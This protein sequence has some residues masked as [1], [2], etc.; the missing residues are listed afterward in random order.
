MKITIHG[1]ARIL[2]LAAALIYL[3]G[4]KRK[5]DTHPPPPVIVEV[6]EV[7]GQDVPVYHDWIGTLEGLVNAQIR[8]Q[9]SGYLLTQNYREGDPVKKGDLLFQIDPRP[10]Q[11]ALDQAKG[12]LAQ[13]EAQSGK[14]ELDVKRFTPLAKVSA[15]SQQELD[16]AVQA[17]LAAKA[18]VT[19]AKAAVEQAKLNLEF[20]H[21][22]SPIDG[23]P[24]I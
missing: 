22:L 1:D 13:A 23:I 4:C 15:I 10:F 7:K 14:T 11:A 5:V 3:A 20:T 12:Q 21:L 2:I 17:N 8:A 18:A 9:V 24:G 16:D 19:A 6:I